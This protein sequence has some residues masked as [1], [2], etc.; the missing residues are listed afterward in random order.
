MRMTRSSKLRPIASLRI[1]ADGSQF[2]ATYLGRPP[3]IS[4]RYC[5]RQSSLDLSDEEVCSE[6]KELALALSRLERGNQTPKRP[7]RTSWRRAWS[8]HALIRELILEIAIGPGTDD[9]DARIWYVGAVICMSSTE[10]TPSSELRAHIEQANDAMPAFVKTDPERLLDDVQHS[11]FRI[12]PGCDDEW[13]PIDVM[14][15]IAV[16]CGMR[17]T[18]FLLERALVLRKQL[19][20]RWLVP[21]ARNLLR[22]V[23][24]IAMMKDYCSD[25]QK[26]LIG[27]VWLGLPGYFA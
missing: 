27:L 18:E 8:Q 11:V 20:S 14:Y 10:L 12:I 19:E 9:P 16:H 1:H 24:Q 13:R 25:F 2:L 15:L 22:L 6:G 21:S 4:Y 26:D 5:I 3:H 23:L 7:H 17:H